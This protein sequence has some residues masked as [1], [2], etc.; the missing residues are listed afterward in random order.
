M[1]HQGIGE[2]AAP[3]LMKVEGG[4]HRIRVRTSLMTLAYEAS[5]V[6]TCSAYSERRK[7]P[8]R[9]TPQNKG[10]ALRYCG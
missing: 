8:R 3:R 5:S 1:C 6:L 9:T 2:R 4:E 10:Q 7:S